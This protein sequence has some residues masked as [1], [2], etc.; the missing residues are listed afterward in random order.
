MSHHSLDHWVLWVHDKCGY[1]DE[2][3]MLW[4]SELEDTPCNNAHIRGQKLIPLKRGVYHLPGA[5][6]W[7]P[8]YHILEQMCPHDWQR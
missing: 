2:T 6:S 8:V 5:G 4:P 1:P 7:K 3:K